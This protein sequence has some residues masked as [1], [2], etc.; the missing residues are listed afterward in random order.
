MEEATHVHTTSR[1]ALHGAAAALPVAAVP[2]AGLASPGADAELLAAY[3]AFLDADRALTACDRTK[4][5]DGPI[6][7]RYYEAL[8]RLTD[9]QPRTPAGLRAKA[10][11]AHAAMA[12]VANELQREE[13]AGFS[14]LADLL[15]GDLAGRG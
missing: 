15:A 4:E 8:E 7:D 1:R 3:Q 14:V 13:M 5:D 11:A 12:S 2:L 6:L 10:E 9:L